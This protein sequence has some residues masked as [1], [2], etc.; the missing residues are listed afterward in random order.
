VNADNFANGGLGAHV[1]SLD[2]RVRFL[3]AAPLATVIRLD[4]AVEQW[5]SMSRPSPYGGS[6]PDLGHLKRATSTA[7]VRYTQYRDDQ[8][9]ARFVGLHRDGSLDFGEGGS[10]A[11][12]RDGR[13][14]WLRPTVGLVWH[15]A[16]MQLEAVERWGV[17]GPFEVSIALAGVDGARLGGF[18]EGWSDFGGVLLRVECNVIDPEALAMDVGEQLENAFGSTRRRF[19]GNRGEYTDRFD[20]RF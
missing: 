20:P 11:H 15:L 10:I 1:D 6:P 13:M 19:L 2:L 5:L 3:P 9:W 8:G 12:R 4:D 7:L 18:A 16:A 17:D 14:V